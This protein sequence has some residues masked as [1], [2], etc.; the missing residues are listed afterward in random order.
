MYRL[1]LYY[2]FSL[3][4]ASVVLS[5][6]HVLPYSPIWLVASSVFILTVCFIANFIF[7]KVLSVPVNVES[8]Y[9]TAMILFFLVTPPLSFLDFSYIGMAFWASVLGIGSKFLVSINK[10]HIFNPA[11]FG[12]AV[13][14]LAL[15]LSA[16]WLR[17]YRSMTSFAL[18]A[19]SRPL[20]G[21][22]G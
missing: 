9:I 13:L 10:K 3:F 1:T 16:S 2:L 5:L 8:V 4:L 22:E 11:A 17:C 20:S 7:S 18:R 14:A 12:V 6:F 21:L 19:R 15:G